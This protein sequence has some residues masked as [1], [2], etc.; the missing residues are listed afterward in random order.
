ME[1]ASIWLFLAKLVVT[2]GAMLLTI[3]LI[4]AI[5]IALNDFRDE[6]RSH[7]LEQTWKPQWADFVMIP[8]WITLEVVCLA[9]LIAWALIVM[10]MLRVSATAFRDW[11]HAG[12]KC[13]H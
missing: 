9:L 3:Y 10:W 7:Y 4:A 6:F 8:I 12:A 11:W 1:E 13:R 2:M 5:S